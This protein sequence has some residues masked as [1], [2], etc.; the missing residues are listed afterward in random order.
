MNRAL[1]GFAFGLALALGCLGPAEFGGG[2]VL[3]APFN[4][5]TALIKSFTHSGRSS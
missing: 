4:A 3:D 2:G 1:L 5:V